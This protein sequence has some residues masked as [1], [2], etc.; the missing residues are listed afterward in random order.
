MVEWRRNKV[1]EFLIQ[2]Y[3]QWDIA[4]N[5]KVDQST[6]SRDMDYL[7]QQ[8]KDKVRNT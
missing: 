3:S 5:L 6:I 4:N 7:R 2:G 1:Q 8:A